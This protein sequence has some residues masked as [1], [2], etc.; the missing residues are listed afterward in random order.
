MAKKR[1]KTL[2]HIDLDNKEFQDVWRLLRF[3]RQSVFMT[4]RAGSGKSTFLRYITENI[5]K[6][7][8]VLA[9]TGIAAVNVGGQTLHS[10][11]RLP[12]RPV[13][14]DDPDFQYTR[15]R[16]RMKYPRS[17]QRLIKRL[18]LIIIDEVSMVRADTIDLI[19]RLLRYFG[20]NMREPFG[21]KQLL[22]V[23][24][25][26]QLEPVVT[27]D[28]RIVLSRY[29]RTAYF[30]NALAFRDLN[31][32]PIELQQVYRQRDSEFVSLL[33]RV[34]VGC[35]TAADFDA[36]NA[37]VTGRPQAGDDRPVMTLAT[38]R[39]LVD[40]INNERLAAIDAPPKTYV[41]KITG[42][43]PESSLPTELSLTLKA[44]AQVVF[45]KNDFERRWVNGTIGTVR[46]LSD[47]SIEVELE[48][49]AVHDVAPEVWSNVKYEYDEKSRRV[50]ERELGSF[51]Q[52]PVRLAWALTIHKSQGL[53]FNRVNIDM[54]SGAFSSGQTYVALSRCVSLEGMTLASTVSQRDI[55]VN[56][57]IVRFSETFNDPVA[58][59]NAIS[60]A[61][62]DDEYN[63]AARNLD[64]C[65][66]VESFDHYVEAAATR[67]V[68]P[69]DASV[70]RLIRRK[71]GRAEA[72]I[73]R[74]GALEAELARLHDKLEELAME[75]VV[76]GNDCLDNGMLEPAIANY[77]K[78][79]SLNPECLP[80]RTARERA[81]RDYGVD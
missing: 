60:L 3:T 18:D 42:E 24:D 7:F 63:K 66:L 46:S 20:G 5:K 39:D 8:V 1:K 65:R 14:P 21:G 81:M 53:T 69:G 62:S 58:I 57:A 37:R 48:S 6:K 34:R 56:P 64:E 27:A 33:D 2:T 41:G 72:R 52:F 30:F 40:H 28:T 12:L 59:E 43:F 31:I 47:D 68:V 75:Y 16:E 55:T 70:V 51:A 74:V 77:D 15:L 35:P 4:G 79:L 78:A 13:L 61:K 71:L 45:I 54:G 49:G 11:F 38:R 44:G 50:I 25:V 22:L 76:M 67:N 32:V 80:A 26:F 36:I 9:P 10:F 19:D 29:Y 17:L 23:G 73:A